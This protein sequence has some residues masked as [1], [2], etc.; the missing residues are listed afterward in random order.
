MKKVSASI[1]TYNN[2]NEILGV[3][4]S[5]YNTSDSFGLEVYLVD[6]H[7]TDKTV[8]RVKEKYPECNILQMEKN[9]GYGSGH[10]RAISVVESEYHMVI[11]PDIVF[12]DGIISQFIEYMDSNPDIALCSPKVLNRD[13][14]TQYLPKQR[15]SMKFLLGGF[16][17]TKSNIFR[18]WRQEFTMANIQIIDPVEIDFIS[19]CFMFFRT[20]VLKKCGGF[21]ERYFMYFED[22]DITRKIQKLGKTIYNPAIEV[23]HEWKREN[24]TLR[25][26]LRQVSSMFKYFFKWELPKLAK[27]GN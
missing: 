4:N 24:R 26:F 13:G 5:L 23:T 15:P 10:N 18:H 17:E 8:E 7:S 9:L 16:F 14:S 12:T 25:G 6:N 19:G 21:D 11:N 20:E 27:K 3:L 2:E 22:A 1:V